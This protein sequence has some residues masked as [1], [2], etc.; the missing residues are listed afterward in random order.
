[1]EDRAEALSALFGLPEHVVPICV[2]PIGH[3]KST[4][5]PEDR[6]LPERVHLDRW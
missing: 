3:P 5:K 2:I 6:Y 1:M 4:P